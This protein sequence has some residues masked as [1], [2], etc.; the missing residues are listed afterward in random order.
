MDTVLTILKLHGALTLCMLGNFSGFICHLLTFSKIIFR[1][2]CYQCQKSL[3]PDQDLHSVGP[4]LGPN[5]LQRL[6]ADNNQIRVC[7]ENYFSYFSTKTYVVGTQKNRLNDGS[8]EHPKHMFK[9]MDKEIIAIL[10]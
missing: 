5:C 1:N 9:T 7:N 4:D 3:D 10:S 6:S 8:F 2:T